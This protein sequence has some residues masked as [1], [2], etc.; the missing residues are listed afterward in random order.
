MDKMSAMKKDMAQ[1]IA[2][3]KKGQDAALNKTGIKISK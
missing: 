3:L 1:G 2:A